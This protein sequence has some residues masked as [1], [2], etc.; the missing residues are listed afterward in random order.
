[1]E[2]YA[3]PCLTYHLERLQC[4]RAALEAEIARTRREL[5]LADAFAEGRRSL[6]AGM[7]LD[8]CPFDDGEQRKRWFMIGYQQGSVQACNTFAPN[9]RL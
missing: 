9:V 5:D 1:M 7:L 4:D 3:I 8:A 2:L 6:G